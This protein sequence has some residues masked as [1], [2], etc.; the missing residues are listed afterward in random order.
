[1][2]IGVEDPAPSM[3]VVA[4]ERVDDD[5][6]ADWDR[7]TVD[8]PGGHVHQSTANAAHR[9]EQ[10]WRPRFATFADGRSTL[11]LTKRHTPL[12]GLIAYAPRGPVAAGDPP[13][14]VAA[15]LLGLV[16]WARD[17]GVVVLAADPILQADA[18][19]ERTLA[20]AGFR[21]IDE[22]H[23]ERNRMVLALQA[24]ADAASVL[25]GLPSATR[26]EIRAA[27]RA[28]TSVEAA[29]D[30]GSI[31][32]FG[33]L[34]AETARRREFWIG[35]VGPMLRWWRRLVE[36]EL[37]LL[38]VARNAGRLVGGL[39]LY[40]QGGGFFMAHAGDDA[41]TRGTLRGTSHVLAWEAIRRAVEAG[42]RVF[43]MGGVEPPGARRMPEPGESTYGLYRYKRSFGA[44]WV[45][46][47]AAHEIVLRP[48]VHAAM[49]SASALRRLVRRR[50]PPGAAG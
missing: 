33:T 23:A 20:A 49:R 42:D 13:E 27:G 30:P 25:A 31:E 4:V 2:T 12:P 48:G 26:Y 29:T 15:R 19:Y 37:G 35:N 9:A 45:D 44:E 7:R 21:V 34:Y 18:A 3:D 41:G 50:R 28:G 17:A 6:P 38:L 11:L 36:A 5:A 39:L 1:M 8:V 22:L 47:A 43:D 40:R 46:C 24:G 10:G 14:R 16:E 32:R